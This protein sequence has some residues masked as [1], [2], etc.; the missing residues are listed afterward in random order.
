MTEKRTVK[1]LIRKSRE[2]PLAV[3]LQALARSSM[4]EAQ[5]KL[6]KT[7]AHYYP[8]LHPSMI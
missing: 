3:R 2:M 6:R 4:V 8:F 1:L 7:E 5:I